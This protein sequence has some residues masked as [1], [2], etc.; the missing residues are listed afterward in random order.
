MSGV[1]VGVPLAWTSGL[2]FFLPAARFS[3]E[4]ASDCLRHRGFVR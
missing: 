3:S 1:P 4:I 2:V